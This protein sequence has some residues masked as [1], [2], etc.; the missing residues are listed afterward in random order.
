MHHCITYHYENQT[1]VVC[2][3]SLLWWA[4]VRNENEKV[5]I[6]FDLNILFCQNTQKFRGERELILIRKCLECTKFQGKP[7]FKATN[8]QIIQ[9]R[10]IKLDLLICDLVKKLFFY[11]N[12]STR[13]MYI[14]WNGHSVTWWWWCGT[15]LLLLFCFVFSCPFIVIPVFHQNTK[16]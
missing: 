5:Q 15:L 11:A 2:R 10:W 3:C 8:R 14:M 12:A 7:L 1:Q 13:V 6:S 4:D 16:D 9:M